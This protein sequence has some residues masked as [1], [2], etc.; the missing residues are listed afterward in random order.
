MSFFTTAVTF[1][2]AMLGAAVGYVFEG[3]RQRRR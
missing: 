1:I 2:A 3:W